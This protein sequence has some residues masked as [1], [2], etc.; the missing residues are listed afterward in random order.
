MI[1]FLCSL[2]F[3]IIG[4]AA[5]VL[6]F[7]KLSTL[8]SLKVLEEVFEKKLLEVA[9]MMHECSSAQ[10]MDQLKIKEKAIADV[11]NVIKMAIVNLRKRGRKC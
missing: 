3:L 1:V 8:S 2:V 4:F 11:I 7:A 10:E 5:G 6:S 9:K